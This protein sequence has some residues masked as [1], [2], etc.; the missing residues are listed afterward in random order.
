VHVVLCLP[1]AEGPPSSRRLDNREEGYMHT[2]SRILARLRS[3]RGFSL[4]EVLVG[5]LVLVVGLIAISQFFASAAARVLDSDIRSVLHQAATQEVESIRG[6]PYDEVGTQDGHP[7]GILPADED[8]VFENMTVH[9]HRDVVYWTDESYEGPYPANY[10]RVTVTVS[11]AGRPAIKPVELVTNV[12][13]GAEGGTLDVTVTDVRGR[14]VPDA[15]IAITNDHLAPPVDIHSSAIKTD[16]SGHLFVPGLEPDDTPSYVVTASKSGYNSDYTDPAVVVLDGFPYTVVHLIIDLLSDMVIKVE[17]TAGNPVE[18]LD[19]TVLG[20]KGFEEG[21][22]STADG[23]LLDDIRYS[24]DL[25]PYVVVL[26]PTEDY[27]RQEIKVVLDPGTTQEVVV[28]VPVIEETTTTTEGSGPTTTEPS[29][30]TTVSST[31]T[32]LRHSLRITVYRYGSAVP[33]QNAKV[34]LDNGWSGRTGANGWVFFDNLEATTYGVTITRTNYQ[35][36]E[37]DVEV[38]GATEITVYL[39]RNW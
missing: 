23:V 22:V 11:A 10:R 15:L 7:Q 9:V 19:L 14:P 35:R 34:V 5:G 32:T 21:I 25:E 20:P 16:S 27:E 29:T 13:G 39:H 8:V 31:T 36:L 6:L 12:A 2:V 33:V 38:N 18:G 4:V 3:Q 30:T 24:T 1:M 26:E 28:V 17:D 37:T